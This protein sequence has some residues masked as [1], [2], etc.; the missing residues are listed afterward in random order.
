MNYETII[1]PIKKMLFYNV[2]RKAKIC[3]MPGKALACHKDLGS[4]LSPKLK[5]FHEQSNPAY[6]PG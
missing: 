4:I 2:H 1:N 3:W 6:Y 5:F